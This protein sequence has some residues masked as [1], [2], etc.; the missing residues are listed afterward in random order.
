MYALAIPALNR[1]TVE[2]CAK[3]LNVFVSNVAGVDLLTR[4][5]RDGGLCKALVDWCPKRQ[6]TENPRVSKR[7]TTKQ[8]VFES[9][10]VYR[11]VVCFAS[12]IHQ[13]PTGEQ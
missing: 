3:C 7:K 13:P 10:K 9:V 5:M 4:P 12:V 1:C 8:L 2:Q 6:Y 11:I